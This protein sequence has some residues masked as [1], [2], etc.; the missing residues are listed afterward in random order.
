MT[1]YKRF[2]PNLLSG[3]WI[4]MMIAMWLAFA[5]VQAGGMASYIIVIG[6]S[7]EPNFH[8]GDLV[9][10]HEEAQYQVGDAVVYKNRELENFVFHR[11]ISQS[12]GRFTLKGDNNT[13]TDT[14]QPA[15]EELLGKLWL[16]IPKGGSAIQKMRSP[17]AMALIAG[18]L[19]GVLAASILKGK[20]KGRKNMNRNSVREWFAL[21]KQ[22]AGNRLANAKSFE[23]QKTESNQR[24]LLEASF[25]V[26]GLVVFASL[27]LAIV[28]FS[29]PATRTAQDDVRYEHL[30]FFSY[31]ASAPQ[32]VYDSNYIKS[33]DP[34]FPRLTCSVDMTFR[35][36]LVAVEVNQ[37]A[38]TYQ[39]TATISEQASGWQRIVSLQEK[40]SFTGN[41]FDAHATLDLC[42]MEALT[43]SME[44]GTDF[45]PGTYI[46]T[47]TPN[48]SM[49]G[50]VSGRTLQT[51]YNPK[52][53][54]VYDRVHFYLVQDDKGGNFLNVNE[55]G[56]L[57]QK[58]TEANTIH[59]PGTELAIPRLRWISVIGLISSLGGL[60]VLGMQLQNLSRSD[61]VKFARV[62]YDS[63][64]VDV[65][66]A[67][68]VN[69]SNV[70]DVGS[71]DDLAK[72]AERFNAMILHAKE[73]DAHA[74]YVQGE[75]I[76]YRFVMN[77]HQTDPAVP[78]KDAS[79]Q[80][81]EK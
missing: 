65:Q 45:R 57:S 48:I 41:A 80:E 13:W 33:G 39:L 4:V 5:P 67:N 44:Q 81:G 40:A 7:M 61:Q 9:I 62:R 63:I 64:M 70:I 69:A 35:Y 31:S 32:G 21:V 73:R 58:R 55:S 24:N 37:L 22:K 28:S 1:I 20:P 36:T 16:H 78:A 3:F 72:L 38:G 56:I 8:I 66:N 19:G 6:N 25:F 79:S 2:S 17:F 76:T 29:R 18:V 60:V 47:I 12:M 43:Q 50:N 74:Y 27:I 34:I 68:S 30:G 71:I 52:L 75:G 15:R 10:V 14:Y 51:T 54:F 26:L 77:P 53:A 42:R 46:L 11:I 49:D 23:T 59:L